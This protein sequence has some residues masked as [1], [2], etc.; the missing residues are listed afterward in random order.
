MIPWAAGTVFSLAI[1]Y[2]SDKL[3]KRFI[4]IMAC[5]VFAFAGNVLL[6]TIHTN[7][8]AELAGVVM[9]LMGV[10]AASPI[11]ICWYAMNLNGHHERAVGIPWQLGLGNVSGIIST[12]AFPSKD[13]PRYTLGYSLGLGFLCFGA[14]VCVLYYVRCKIENQRL[15][16]QKYVL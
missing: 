11:T 15:G 1:A 3:Q 4:V 2:I 10:V 9:Y 7:R 16:R 8:K 13:A 14:A 12:F 5:L 6:L